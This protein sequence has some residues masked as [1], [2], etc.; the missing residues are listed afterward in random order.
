MSSTT[1]TD[2]PDAH[3]MQYMRLG[4]TGLQVSRIC[5]GMMSYGSPEWQPWVLDADQSL[6][7]LQAAWDAGINFFDSADI[8]SN[9]ESERILG[10][11]MR[12]SGIKRTEIVVATKL[13]GH[14]ADSPSINTFAVPLPKHA[15]VNQM[16][17]SRKHIFDAVDASLERLGTD[18][19]DLYQIHRWDHNT[20]IEETMEALN[21]LVRMGKVRYIGASSMYA[22]QFAKAQAVAERNGWAKFVSMQNLVNLLYREEEREMLPLCRDQGVG[23]IPWSPLARGILSGKG[24][25]SDSVRAQTDRA[26]KAQADGNAAEDVA[27]ATDDRILAALRKVAEARG[28]PMSQ[29]ALAWVLAKPGVTAPIVGMNKVEYLHDAVA[30]LS[31]KL[32]DDEIKELEAPYY[33]KAV[34]GNL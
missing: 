7:L 3:K 11:F 32:T 2:R 20:P 1:S 21:D 13:F 15:S 33:P 17:L 34:Y 8:Y 29:V 9:G 25:Q 5:V 28:A 22:W 18:Y 31:I 30:A 6:P 16:G 26:R 24:K 10:R 14:V 23:V 12:E 27:A 4:K 19:I